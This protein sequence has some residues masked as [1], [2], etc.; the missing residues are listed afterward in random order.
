MKSVKLARTLGLGVT[1]ALVVGAF[2]F[3]AASAAP[4]YT[5]EAT[6]Q[7]GSAFQPTD[8][9]AGDITV[10]V[11]DGTDDVDV[12][13][14][15]DL[16]Y[17]WTVTP[18][19]PGAADVRVPLTDEDVQATDVA[20]EFVVPLPVAQGTGVYELTAGL[21]AD[22]NG[23][24]AV[25]MAP[26]LAVTV[27]SEI[28]AGGTAVV[29]GLGNGTP[30]VAQDGTLTVTAPDDTYGTDAGTDRDPVAGQVFTL[31]VDHGFFTTGHGPL[32]SVVG[33]PAG[34]LER[35][36]TT[37]TGVTDADGSIDFSIGIGRDGG[38]DDDG[39]VSAQVTVPGGTTG[40]S[41]AWS[42]AGTLNGQVAI[43]IAPASEQ[44]GPVNPAL[45]GDRTLF[46]VFALDQFGNRVGGVPIELGY[47]G[48]TKDWD[49]SDD[50]TVSD[51][52]TFGD[53]WVLSNLAGRIDVT[54]TWEEAPTYLY[55]DTSGT[56]VT[57]KADVTGSAASTTYELNFDASR[58]SISSSVTDTVRVGSAVT[59]TVRVVDQQ[60]NPV[61][62]Y[63][64]RFLRYGPDDIRGEVVATRATNALGEATYSFV[65]T[66]RGR[67]TV[68]AEVSDGNRRR[69]LTASV[70]F[71]AVVKARLLRDRS[72]RVSNRSADRLRIITRAEAA[73]ARVLLYRITRGKQVLVGSKKLNSKG[74]VAFKIRDRNRSARTT[75][76]AVVR[77]TSNSIADQSNTVKIR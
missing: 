7:D 6:S 10:Q 62:G 58:F 73:G 1:A 49:Y 19:T 3:T 38:F 42:T 57:D 43:A 36:G 35:L 28:P 45:A 9:A 8:Y 74:E 67:A 44:D 30:G 16:T 56:A 52:D 48:Y 32:P 66:R 12:D 59:Q 21:E 65:G 29:A 37:L 71:G 24:S 34:D 69:E 64:V 33:T 76:R 20:G 61:E 2:P 25:P 55:T 70:A 13:D 47:S 5:L 22:A 4:A 75:Y 18:F 53:I 46:D 23:D 17:F 26:L 27:G 40:T 51:F 41:A 50:F 39:L 68:T 14:S 31:S 15:Q 63:Q 54:G 72:K 77:S 11:T 60:G